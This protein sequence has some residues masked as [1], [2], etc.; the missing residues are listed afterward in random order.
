MMS[1]PEPSKAADL[2]APRGLQP[3]P[4]MGARAGRRPE[5]QASPPRGDIHELPVNSPQRPRL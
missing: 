5:G 4:E 3:A 2:A 1:E